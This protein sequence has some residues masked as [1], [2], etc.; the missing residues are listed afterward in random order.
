MGKGAPVLTNSLYK[1]SDRI[2]QAA[3]V[4]DQG[5]S[6]DGKTAPV[7]AQTV[8]EKSLTKPIPPERIL[9]FGRMRHDLEIRIEGMLAEYRCEAEILRTRGHDLESAAA[10]VET[11][12]KELSETELPGTEEADAEKQLSKRLRAMELMRL[13]TIRLSKKMEAG[14]GT[15]AGMA[16]NQK[17]WP[18]LMNI[19]GGE[20]MKK[21]FAF[22]FPLGLTILLCTILLGLSFIVAWKVAL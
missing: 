6:P 15:G 1:I 19:P 18:D 2:A 14:R 7:P 10:Q 16:A 21:G 5:T 9:E 22:F 11:L 12:K 20:I 17:S 3:N 4:K 13:E 8:P